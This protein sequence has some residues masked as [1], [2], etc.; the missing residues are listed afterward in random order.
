[1][2]PRLTH[3]VGAIGQ[4]KIRAR[5][6]GRVED[7]VK[8]HHEVLARQLVVVAK[9]VDPLVGIQLQA[10]KVLSHPLHMN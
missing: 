4:Q 7:M 6:F 2:R 8:H 9:V 5:R 1:M 3:E 10:V